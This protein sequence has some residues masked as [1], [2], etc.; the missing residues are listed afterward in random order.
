MQ[1]YWI[2]KY[3]QY[4][5][6]GVGEPQARILLLKKY[7]SSSS[8]HYY[9]YQG[10]EPSWLQKLD[11]DQIIQEV[12]D[13]KNVKKDVQ[14]KPI[15]VQLAEL[16]YKVHNDY[17]FLMLSKIHIHVR[18]GFNLQ[19]FLFS[20]KSQ[21]IDQSLEIK[22]L[23]FDIIQPTGSLKVTAMIQLVEFNLSASR[24]L[25]PDQGQSRLGIFQKT[26]KDNKSLNSSM[27]SSQGQTII[28][29]S[30]MAVQIEI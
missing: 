7:I 24:Y 8:V 1:V 30:N 22:N 21:I 11:F 2:M 29:F 4:L 13:K 23:L 9:R 17:F 14:K 12:N 26:G 27:V 25:I 15:E 19:V 20:R 18:A 5:Q 10:K 3:R 28:S 6:Y 16:N